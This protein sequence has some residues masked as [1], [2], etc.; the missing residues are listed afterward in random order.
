MACVL[1]DAAAAARLSQGPGPSQ[2][3]PSMHGSRWARPERGLSDERPR[4]WCHGRNTGRQRDDGSVR[5]DDTVARWHKPGETCLRRDSITPPLASSRRS[6]K[7]PVA[8]ARPQ[9]VAECLL[10]RARRRCRRG[11]SE[12]GWVVERGPERGTPWWPNPNLRREAR[13]LRAAQGVGRG[14]R[15]ESTQA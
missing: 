11:S 7:S 15:L 8:A 2:H 14:D 6:P 4:A 1:Y 9:P 10:A 5:G 3:M 13:P 12:S